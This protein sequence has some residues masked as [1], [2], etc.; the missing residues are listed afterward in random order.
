MESASQRNKNKKAKRAPH[1]HKAQSTR[2]T[3]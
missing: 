1:A 2:F 3:Y